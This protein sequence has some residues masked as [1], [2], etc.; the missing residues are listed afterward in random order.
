M[1]DQVSSDVWVV[2]DAGRTVC[3]GRG[4]DG[5]VGAQEGVQAAG[6][7][8]LDPP[9][10]DPA[11]PTLA[12]LDS[13]SDQQLDLVAAPAAAARRVVL[14]AAGDQP[15]VRLDQARQRHALRRDHGP[16]QPGCEQPCGLVGPLGRTASGVAAPR[17]RWSAWP[18]DRRPRTM[19]S[20]PAWSRASPYRPSPKSA[21]D[22][23]RIHGCG[24]WSRVSILGCC[25]R[26]DRRSLPASAAA[27][28]RRHWLPGQGNAPGTP[29]GNGGVGHFW[30]SRGHCV[31]IVFY[32]EPHPRTPHFVAPDAR[33]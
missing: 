11:G 23:R 1:G 25:R 30:A 9:H 13:A 3:S 32:N 31:P 24:P 6:G 33:G 27:T 5:E 4:A 22:S 2:C 29:T 7:E 14:G 19:R 10:A 28:G 12:D 21:C 18:S 16:A 8:V 26:P 17:S 20:A 15:F